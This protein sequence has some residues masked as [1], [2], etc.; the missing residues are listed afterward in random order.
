MNYQTPTP[1]TL[2]LETPKQ[3]LNINWGNPSDASGLPVHTPKVNPTNKFNILKTVGVGVST[4]GIA[5]GLNYQLIGMVNVE[6]QKN[7]ELIQTN[8]LLIERQQRINYAQANFAQ[9]V[10]TYNTE[11]QRINE[12]K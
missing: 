8:Q 5:A 7:K 6:R 4:I 3:Q 10:E 1:Q 11:M 12:I 9:C 2:E